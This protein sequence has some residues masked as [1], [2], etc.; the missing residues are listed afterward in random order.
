MFWQSHHQKQGFHSRVSISALDLE[1]WNQWHNTQPPRFQGERETRV[2][3]NV[4]QV[5][6]TGIWIPRGPMKNQERNDSIPEIAVHFLN[7]C[8]YVKD[9]ENQAF[10][11]G[12]W[13][14][15]GQIESSSLPNPTVC[16][17][18][19]SASPF[20]TLEL[21]TLILFLKF[22]WGVLFLL[23]VHHQILKKSEKASWVWETEWIDSEGLR[24]N[25]C[26]KYLIYIRYHIIRYYNHFI[27]KK[28]MCKKAEEPRPRAGR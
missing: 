9:N 3:T 12:N 24:T 23:V 8:F 28:R 18:I 19:T 22:F 10:L 11:F 7:N 2:H 1:I 26:L 13:S 15:Q 25:S 27:E 6:V 21:F 20:H 5:T 16:G 4:L 14:T 17:S